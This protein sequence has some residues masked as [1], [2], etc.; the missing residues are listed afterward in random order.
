MR[1]FLANKLNPID[2][3]FEFLEMELPAG[4]PNHAVD[5]GGAAAYSCQSR[6]WNVLGVGCDMNPG[7]CRGNSTARLLPTRD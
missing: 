6:K 5:G 1:L 7:P 2:A 4:E 3:K